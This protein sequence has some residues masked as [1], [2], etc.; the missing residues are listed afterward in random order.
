ME[1]RV[2]VAASG[3]GSNLAALLGELAKDGSGARVAL[4]VSN[5]AEAGALAIARRHGI[6]VHVFEN[7]SDPSEWN[8]VLQAAAID[9]VILAGYLKQV[10]ADTVTTWRGR[11]INIHPALL[12]KHGG[13]GMY[14][15]RVHQAVIAAG[16]SQSGATVHLVSEEYDRGRILGQATVPVEPDDTPE[17]LAARVLEVEHRLLPAAVLAAAREGRPVPFRLEDEPRS[18][19]VSQLPSSLAP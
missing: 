18:T 15:A 14:G 19:A 12:P 9:L 2:A 4:V 7:Y 16:D 5:S 17:S 8:R 10:P 11:M 6:P 3:R 13:P 1:M